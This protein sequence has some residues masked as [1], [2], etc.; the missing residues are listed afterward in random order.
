MSRYTAA[1]GA[2]L[3]Q[4]SAMHPAFV[5]VLLEAYQRSAQSGDWWAP[6]AQRLAIELERA[7]R[8][9]QQQKETT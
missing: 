1:P 8:D 9:A 5:P 3:D 4:G 6:E 7:M 2:V